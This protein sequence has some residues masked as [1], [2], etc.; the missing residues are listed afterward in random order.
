MPPRHSLNT[1]DQANGKPEAF[2]KDCGEAALANLVFLFL[3]AQRFLNQTTHPL[4]PC[5]PGA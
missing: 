2:R 4:S 1:L 3:I 5:I